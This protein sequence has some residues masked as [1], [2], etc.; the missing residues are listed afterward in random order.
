MTQSNGNDVE[1]AKSSHNFETLGTLFIKIV[2]SKNLYFLHWPLFTV[3]IYLYI[4][5]FPVAACQ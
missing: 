3:H 4:S 1:V 2:I 5:R